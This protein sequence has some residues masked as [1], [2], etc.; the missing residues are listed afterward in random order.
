MEQLP[1]Q[2][3][4]NA[5]VCSPL[6]PLREQLSPCPRFD[7]LRQALAF[8]DT[9]VGEQT[10]WIESGVYQETLTLQRAN[11]HLVGMGK[12]STIIR[13]GH[14]AAEL[15]SKGKALGTFRTATV[16]VNAPRVTFTHLSIENSF[17][18]PKAL[19]S[20]MG[21]QPEQLAKVHGLQAV[22]LHL[23]AQADQIVLNSVALK[24][25]Q[26]TF[27]TEA[28]R[29]YG[30][31]CH[32]SGTIDFIF[33]GGTLLLEHSD[34]VC[35]EQAFTQR[36]NTTQLSPTGFIAAP[37]TPHH[38]EVG[39]VFHRCR[40]LPASSRV[41][42]NSYAL[43]RPW[44]PTR[45]FSDGDYADPN[46]IGHC[47][48]VHCELGPHISGWAKMHGRGKDGKQR[49][50][51]PHKDARFWEFACTDLAGNHLTHPKEQ[52]QS[53]CDFRPQ[54]SASQAEHLSGIAVLNGWKP[55]VKHLF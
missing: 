27:Y 41:S 18:Y 45:H 36:S 3:L 2:T 11:T 48:Y 50:F 7:T 30:Y 9:Q 15:D 40:I 5:L 1:I 44:H 8:V 26:D 46:A 55:K 20:Q 23:G 19:A 43:A 21:H 16:T 31:D 28:K 42:D 6:S 32:I 37:S 49:C 52:H 51:Y 34:I 47:A 54:L 14:Y 4:P 24:G 39:F 13:A 29:C 53:L 17:D 10:I 22:A 25:Y 12:G 38:Q 35:R 33:G